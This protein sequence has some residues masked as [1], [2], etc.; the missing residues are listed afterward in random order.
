MQRGELDTRVLALELVEDEHVLVRQVAQ[1]RQLLEQRGF[2]LLGVGARRPD[3][4]LKR[5]LD[6]F[7]QPLDVRH[8]LDVGPVCS[9]NR[10]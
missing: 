10:N 3:L 2:E 1:N 7:A 4:H 9:G 8:L 5:A 6:A